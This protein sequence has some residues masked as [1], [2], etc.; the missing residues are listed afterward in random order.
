MKRRKFIKTGVLASAV[1]A[2]GV[3]ARSGTKLRMGSK[4]YG[5]KNNPEAWVKWHQERGYR[6]AYCPVGVDADSILI[7]A[8]EMAAKS[9]DIVIAEVGAWCNPLSPDSEQASQA[10]EKLTNHLALAD[11]IDAKCCVNISG[12]KNVDNWA[13]PHPDNLTST[14]FDQI[15][16]VTRSIIDTVKPKRTFF[17]LETMPWAYPVSV[18]SYVDLIEAIDRK[19]FAV[20]FDPVNLINS[21]ERYFSNAQII[22]EGFAKLGP[23]MKSVHAKDILLS[24]NLTTHLDEVRIGL[25]RMDYNVFLQELARYPEVP[26]ML[27][28]LENEQEYD[29][30][31]K[32]V[33]E[34]AAQVG[35]EI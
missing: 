19:G 5:P 20:H 7:R 21:P 11:E 32:A 2:A 18:E 27:E 3:Q 23:L 1:Y 31:T 22:K 17:T 34:V 29:L 35:V 30:A 10:M 26:L 6:A 33:R 15:V 13:G 12:S 25:G 4:Y 28:H 8:F 9:A 16:Q 24:E 14:T